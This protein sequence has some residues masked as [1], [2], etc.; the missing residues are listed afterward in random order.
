[1][2]CNASLA[3]LGMPLVSVVMS[4]LATDDSALELAAAVKMV[5]AADVPTVNE[6]DELND[7]VPPTVIESPIAAA[8]NAPRTSALAVP[9]L[10]C[11]VVELLATRLLVTPMS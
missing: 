10:P 8:S 2:T 4:M 5:P 6:P 7:S 1:M 3:P 9:V 11:S